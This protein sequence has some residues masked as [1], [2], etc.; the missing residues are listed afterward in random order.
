MVAIF[1]F[2]CVISNNLYARVCLFILWG[3]NFC[4]FGWFIIHDNL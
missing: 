2:Y 4:G 1:V 3:S